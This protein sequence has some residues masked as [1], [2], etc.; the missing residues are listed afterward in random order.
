LLATLLGWI[1]FLFLSWQLALPLYAIAVIISLVIYWKIIKAQR[2][3]SVIGKRAMI[4]G[5][6]LVAR[7]KGDNI[8][9]EYDGEL[10]RAASPEPLQQ[11][12]QVT[13]KGVEGLILM[14]VPVKPAGDADGSF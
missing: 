13:I 2:K 12:Q 10:W 9:V 14:V 4:G 8:E 11:G 7:V 6:A 5:Q 1:L 3:V